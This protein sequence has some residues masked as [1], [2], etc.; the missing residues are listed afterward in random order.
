MTTTVLAPEPA[1]PPG[2]PLVGN[3]IDLLKDPLGYAIQV[4][5]RFGP[6]AALKL[7]GQRMVLVQ[8]P[9]GVRQ[10]LWEKGDLYPKPRLGMDTLA[11]LLGHGIA[12]LTDRDAWSEARTF[13]LPLFSAPMLKAYFKEAVESIEA[14][15]AM[16]SRHADTGVAINIYD[17][18]HE[19]TFRVLLRTVFRDAFRP[20]E[21]SELTHLFNETTAY[22]NV[23]YLTLGMPVEWALG[24]ARRGKR[25]LETLNARVYALIA[26]RRAEGRTESRDML[27]VLLAARKQDGAALSDKEI[28]DNCMTM[29]FGGH[30]TTAGSVTWAWGLLAANPDKREAMMHEIDGT[31]GTSAPQSLDDLRRLPFVSW[32]FEE[33]MR[34]YPMFSFLLRE[35]AQD[36]VIEGRKIHR[37]DLVAFSAFS[38][39]HDPAVW[40]DPERFQPERHDP[41]RRGERHKSSFLSFS[42]GQRGCI[43]ERM[44]RMEGV[45]LLTLLSQRYQLDLDGPLPKPKVS[46]SLKP[47]GGLWM[48]V[49]RRTATST[50]A[51]SEIPA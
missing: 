30:E 39:H 21:V 31:L 13:I 19:A 33:A 8:S 49:R 24:P 51:A 32:V 5:E 12:T 46:M 4:R 3:A 10:I 36:D 41:A 29:L 2:L 17:W 37:G 20:D 43:G 1:T 42:Q 22:I 18:M 35:A 6:V 16:L 40:A 47:D 26:A 23:R 25:A 14:E 38:I 48:Q 50:D 44:A 34:L 27:D 28:R 7:G 11:P 9:D 45:L 15:V